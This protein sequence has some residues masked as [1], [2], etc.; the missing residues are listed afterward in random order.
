MHPPNHRY[1]EVS[2]RSATAG[3]RHRGPIG[4]D[5]AVG[6]A[7]LPG[8]HGPSARA[9]SR[10]SGRWSEPPREAALPAP[11]NLLALDSTPRTRCRRSLG[12]KA[13]NRDITPGGVGLEEPTGLEPKL[14]PASPLDLT[15]C[16][17]PSASASA[18]AGDFAA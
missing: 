14:E 18:G 17:A 10:R 15:G 6:V 5:P 1:L 8:R 13:T 12:Q 4:S 7:A 9:S 11:R 16:L 3:F 2:L